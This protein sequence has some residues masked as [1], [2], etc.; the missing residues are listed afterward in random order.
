MINKGNNMTR[1]ILLA[2]VTVLVAACAAPTAPVAAAPAQSPRA[3]SNIASWTAYREF[4]FEPTVADVSISDAPKLRE[5]VAYLESN[6]SLDVGIDGLLGAEGISPADRSLS[7]R[8]A[9]A[10]RRALMDTGAGV[11]SY[12]IVMGPLDQA[13]HGRAGQIQVLVG[14]R[15]G[16][17]APAVVSR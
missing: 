10:V 2:A 12:K 3:D 7:E 17:P 6:P 14:P 5:I 9:A 13:N 4:N 11:A 1:V 15:N 8:R 16:S